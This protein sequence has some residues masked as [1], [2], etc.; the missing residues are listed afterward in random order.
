MS[1]SRSDHVKN[2]R[3]S[4]L[5]SSE[6]SSAAKRFCSSSSVCSPSSRLR[7]K[8]LNSARSWHRLGLSSASSN[9]VELWGVP[10]PS[11]SSSLFVGSASDPDSGRSLML[12]TGAS[13]RE[14]Q[15][16]NPQ[17]QFPPF[18]RTKSSM[19][20]D[21]L[22]STIGLSALHT[23]TRFARHNAAFRTFRSAECAKLLVNLPV[24]NSTMAASAAGA[25][26]QYGNGA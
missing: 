15:L 24:G 21:T 7:T 9:S 12:N 16:P 10:G 19:H 22:I 17:P 8:A 4:R 1:A 14:V 26:L 25:S 20:R 13:Q 23:C 11:P 3:I 18:L 6:V 2:S 5:L